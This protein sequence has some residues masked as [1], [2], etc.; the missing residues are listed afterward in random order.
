MDDDVSDF[1]DFID[2]IPDP[3]EREARRRDPMFR[4]WITLYLGMSDEGRARF[5]RSAQRMAALPAELR[6][7]MTDAEFDRY[8]NDD[9]GGSVN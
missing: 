8:L 2:R 5:V 3:E 7:R 4:Q 9:T 6:E 1:D